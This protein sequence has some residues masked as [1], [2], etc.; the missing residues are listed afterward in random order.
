MSTH[1]EKIRWENCSI[2]ASIVLWRRNNKLKKKMNIESWYG[3]SS[4]VISMNVGF[5][6]V[7]WLVLTVC[8]VL[9]KLA[10]WILHDR[11]FEFSA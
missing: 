9:L 3:T 1:F 8:E 10:R 7:F 5:R 2:L 4:G 11:D 6:V